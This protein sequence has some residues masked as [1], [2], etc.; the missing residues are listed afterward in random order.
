MN[1][2]CALARSWLNECKGHAEC[3]DADETALPTRI[4]ALSRTDHNSP[5]EIRLVESNG[6]KGRYIALSHCWGSAEKPLSTTRDNLHEHHSNIPF[7]QLGKTFQDVVTL[8]YGSGI[9]LVWIDSLC[10]LQGDNGDWH[11]EALMMRNVYR[12]AALVVLASGARDGS[13]GLFVTDRKPLIRY[14]LPYIQDGVRHGAFNLAVYPPGDINPTHGH[15]HSR[16]WALQE[17]RLARRI[18]AFTRGGISWQCEVMKVDESGHDQE[19]WWDEDD[20]WLSLL[21]SYTKK[22]LTY[23]SDRIE[24]L[25]GVVAE[26]STYRSYR[27]ALFHSELGVWEHGPDGLERQLLWKHVTLDTYSAPLTQIPT[28]SWAATGGE[29]VWVRG[30][31]DRY[32][33]ILMSGTVRITSPKVLYARGN[34]TT[35]EME[36]ARVPA[37]LYTSYAR[38]VYD[39]NIMYDSPNCTNGP[40]RFI[41]GSEARTS[42]LGV[43]IFDE[44]HPM[45]LA[46]CFFMLK[47]GNCKLFN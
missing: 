36:M 8:A 30:D 41:F 35:R 20:T 32:R 18:M 22:D 23:S 31:V 6:R 4:L 43:A 24:A 12:N 25:Q 29:K 45:P 37:E 40:A 46:K 11:S 10:I 39:D 15:L 9:N 21:E 3:P 38:L 13:E 14:R 27:E 33:E 47:R 17:R 28:W 16:A 2:V 1:D 7:D 5:I 42:L 34:M 26:F 44:D 19:F